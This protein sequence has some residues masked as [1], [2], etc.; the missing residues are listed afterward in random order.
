MKRAFRL[1]LTVL[2]LCIFVECSWTPSSRRKQESPRFGVLLVRLN[3]PP[4]KGR[5]VTYAVATA[6]KSRRNEYAGFQPV[7]KDGAA[8]FVLPMN[9]LYDVRIFCDLNG[10]QALDSNEPNALAEGL[11]P[12]PPTVIEVIPVT[13]AFGVVGAVNGGPPRPSTTS[14]V[15]QKSRQEIP[16][17][18]APYMKYIPSWLQDKL[19]E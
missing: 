19:L 7:T 11:V 9:R 4:P 1:S 16:A 10:N 17:E 5:R 14:E 18:I 12:S 8:A 3:T 2:C 13:L 6:Q 15:P